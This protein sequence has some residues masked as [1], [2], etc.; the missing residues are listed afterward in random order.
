L[1]AVY[2]LRHK[3]SVHILPSHF[4]MIHLNISL[5]STLGLFKI[6]SITY[7]FHYSYVSHPSYPSRFKR[8]SYIWRSRDS[9]GVI[10]TW[11]ELEGRSS[12][13]GK[14]KNCFLFAA[15]RSSLEPIQSPIQWVKSYP[16]NRPWRPIGL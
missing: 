3:I 9:S 15:F 7:T 13:S 5:S 8:H 14:S 12:I 6:C 10:G 16:C 1:P 2:V 11:Y 4:Y